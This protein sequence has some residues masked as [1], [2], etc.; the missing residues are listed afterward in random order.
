[1]LHSLKLKIWRD[2]RPHPDHVAA[3][4]VDVVRA[5]PHAK[6]LDVAEDGQPSAKIE[7]A[8]FL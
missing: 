8:T 5:H 2:Q 4:T 1:M 6:V 7:C 3:S